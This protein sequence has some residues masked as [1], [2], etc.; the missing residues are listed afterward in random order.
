MNK[1][2][3][4]TIMI[5][6][7]NE[8]ITLKNAEDFKKAMKEFIEDKP[9]YMILNMKE[10]KYINSTGLGIIA[11]SVMTSRK[12]QK[13]LVIAELQESVKEIFDIVKFASFIKLFAREEEAIKYFQ[14]SGDE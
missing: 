1:R 8:D 14:Q 4:G 5:L 9:E 3:H 12:E 11:D 7:W 13:E 10:V 2:A 6:E